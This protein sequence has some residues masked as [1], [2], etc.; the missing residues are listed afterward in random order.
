MSDMGRNH[1]AGAQLMGDERSGS[2]TQDQSII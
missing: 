2:F 1:H